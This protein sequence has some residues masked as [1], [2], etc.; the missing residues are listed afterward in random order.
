MLVKADR[1]FKVRHLFK[2]NRIIVA[3]NF[4]VRKP[5]WSE[6]FT[7]RW[8]F[9]STRADWGVVRAQQALGDGLAFTSC[10]ATIISKSADAWSISS[11]PL[12]GLCTQPRVR[13][14]LFRHPGF[15]VTAPSANRWC[16][17]QQRVVLLSFAA[18]IYTKFLRARQVP[19][20]NVSALHV[21]SVETATENRVETRADDTRCPFFLSA[22]RG[23]SAHG[24]A[25]WTQTWRFPLFPCEEIAP[26]TF[27]WIPSICA[28]WNSSLGWSNLALRLCV[29]HHDV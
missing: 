26:W 8:R 27:Q 23:R 13:G 4:A 6:L 28:L 16:T 9:A 25:W 19:P 22:R 21:I 3:D 2:G 5:N 29:S 20:R 10:Y 15:Q 12:F 11:K 7:G 1:P 14:N 17:I 24:Q 18:I